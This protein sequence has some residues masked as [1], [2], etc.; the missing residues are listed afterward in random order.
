MKLY[1]TLII[2]SCVAFLSGC[3]TA[4]V[5][6]TFVSN[7]KNAWVEDAGGGG[8]SY[9]IANSDGYKADPVCYAA[10]KSIL[11]STLIVLSGVSLQR[12]INRPM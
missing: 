11:Q 12:L 6:G 10:R 2:G 3:S 9:C 4:S 7:E 8:L 5:H 1:S